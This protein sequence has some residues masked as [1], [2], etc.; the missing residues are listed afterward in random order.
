[1]TRAAR[2]LKTA[3]DSRKQTLYRLNGPLANEVNPVPSTQ[4]SSATT[5]FEFDWQYDFCS[6][7]SLYK[8]EKIIKTTGMYENQILA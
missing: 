4:H 3:C 8:K 2:V 6:A 5:F 1:M 7:G